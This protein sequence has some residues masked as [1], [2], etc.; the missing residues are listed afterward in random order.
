LP[1]EP[2]LSPEY[3]CHST[4]PSRCNPE[5]ARQTHVERRADR[6]RDTVITAWRLWRAR[7]KWWAERD[8]RNMAHQ[9]VAEAEMFLDGAQPPGSA[10]R[11]PDRWP[12]ACHRGQT[13]PPDPGRPTLAARP[14]PPDPGRPTLAVC[15][16]RQARPGPASRRYPPPSRPAGEFPAPGSR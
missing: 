7:R 5:D 9:L 13:R 10:A 11:G 3:A 2:D 6:G 4:Q 1:S 12:V 15:P 14:W 16:E 8:W